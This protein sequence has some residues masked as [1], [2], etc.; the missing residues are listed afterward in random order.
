MQLKMPDNLEILRIS[1]CKIGW[2]VTQELLDYIK[3][4][5]YLKKLDLIKANLNE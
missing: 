1:N 3:L 4:K 5:S 2:K